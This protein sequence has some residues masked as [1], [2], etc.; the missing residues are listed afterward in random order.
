MPL[1]R[2]HRN[3][4]LKFIAYLMF[5]SI[6]PLLV[7]GITSYGISRNVLQAEAQRYA[8]QLLRNQ[9]DYLELQ[10]DQVEALLA[11]VAGVEA[12]SQTLG[13]SRPWADAYTRLATQA[14][15]GYILNNYLNLNGLISI[16]IFTLNGDHYHVGDTLDAG[17]TDAAAVKQMFRLALDSDRAVLWVGVEQNINI[18]SIHKKVVIAAKILRHMNRE[19]LTPKPVALLLANYSTDELYDRFHRIDLGGVPISYSS[20]SRVDLFTIP[21]RS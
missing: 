1:F 15:V 21:T 13:D 7:L 8:L 9:R 17:Q 16:D 5:L 4:A 6:I 18:N 14:R 19:T 10:L 12:I 11:N 20:T 3:I 2:L